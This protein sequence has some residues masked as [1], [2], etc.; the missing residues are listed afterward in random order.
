MVLLK[1]VAVKVFLLY[2]IDMKKVHPTINPVEA[3]M[4]GTLLVA[5]KAKGV[6]LGLFTLALLGTILTTVI[7]FAQEMTRVTQPV[8][9]ESQELT[10][11]QIAALPP[12]IA[13][14]MILALGA[15]LIGV[16]VSAVLDYISAKSAQGKNIPLMD[17][18]KTAFQQYG[19]YLL[20]MCIVFV[21]TLLWSLLFIVP[22]IYKSYR[23]GFAGVAYFSDPEKYRGATAV[24]YSYAITRNSW[25]TVA[26]S[27][28]LVNMATS[29]AAL[30]LL[31]GL[32]TEL[33]KVLSDMHEKQEAAPSPHW[34]SALSIFISILLAMILITIFLAGASQFALQQ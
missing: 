30:P 19:G 20:V 10:Q 31:L 16:Y 9:V 8:A 15:I 27:T 13:F 12:V 11:A 2:T 7:S 1:H 23:Y 14:L 6:I 32:R 29:L 28:S 34:L 21:R 18:L 17:A 5:K 24:D 22:G 3:T 26:G 33:Y 25:I 4:H